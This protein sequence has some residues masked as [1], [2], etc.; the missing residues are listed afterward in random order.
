MDNHTTTS[1]NENSTT[2]NTGAKNELNK[3]PMNE[4]DMDVPTIL[5]RL[6]NGS[7]NKFI[8]KIFIGITQRIH[9]TKT[10]LPSILNYTHPHTWFHQYGKFR[11][12][13]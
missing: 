5:V 10:H 1:N 2:K 9:V 4:K 6:S 3:D 7:D 8:S 11:I 12:L 13:S